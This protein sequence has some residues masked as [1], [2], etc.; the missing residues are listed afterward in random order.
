[1]ACCETANVRDVRIAAVRFLCS[2][3]AGFLPG[4]PDPVQNAGVVA[5]E[6]AADL[7]GRKARLMRLQPDPFADP[8]A[9]RQIG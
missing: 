1:M 6:H 7:N 4:I 5:L 9:A 3:I 8:A 2:L